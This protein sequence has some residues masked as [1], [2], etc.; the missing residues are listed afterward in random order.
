[1]AHRLDPPRARADELDTAIL[2]L[3]RE[4]GVLGKET[5]SGMQ[6]V[7]PGTFEERE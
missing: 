5:V 4:L 6:A 2:H 1:V 7:R 3:V